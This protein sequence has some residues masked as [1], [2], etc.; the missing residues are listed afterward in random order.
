MSSGQEE[1]TV[2]TSAFFEQAFVNVRHL[3]HAPITLRQTSIRFEGS[4]FWVTPGV[5]EVQGTHGKELSIE[6]LADAI[7][8]FHKLSLA[9]SR[10][11]VQLADGLLEEWEKWQGVPAATTSVLQPFFGGAPGYGV[12]HGMADTLR[13]VTGYMA[14]FLSA[15]KHRAIPEPDPWRSRLGSALSGAFPLGDYH[16]KSGRLVSHQPGTE[17]MLLLDRTSL[18][19]KSFLKYTDLNPEFIGV[20]TGGG[21]IN[22]QGSTYLLLM[23]EFPTGMPR[24]TA[25]YR[26]CKLNGNIERVNE[27][28]LVDARE[29][30]D[31][32]AA[33]Y[34]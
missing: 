14:S 7:P 22:Y 20:L 33:F 17:W 6:H 28:L 10:Y 24:G 1:R 5:F 16:G 25:I 4:V 23:E 31:E 21:P 15:G 9:D 12:S 34:R 32:L 26:I 27:S 18:H 29:F 13:L 2:K 19:P 30:G 8:L 11:A 3:P